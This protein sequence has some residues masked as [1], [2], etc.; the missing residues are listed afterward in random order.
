M[1]DEKDGHPKHPCRFDSKDT[2]IPLPGSRMCIRHTA[3][4]QMQIGALLPITEGTRISDNMHIVEED[5]DG[6]LRVGPTI[7]ELKSG[8]GPAQVA[9]PE[10]RASWDR[11]FGKQ[12]IG[13]A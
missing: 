11:I 5:A 4:H 7:G 9:T 6:D 8:S 12:T 13:V 1:P 3:D 2:I 10:Y